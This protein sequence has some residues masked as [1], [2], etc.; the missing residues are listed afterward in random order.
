[1]KSITPRKRERLQT[2]LFNN[3]CYSI[4]VILHV[5]RM[6]RLTGKRKRME[7]RKEQAGRGKNSN[8]LR[9]KRDT[10]DRQRG[11]NDLR[12]YIHTRTER[13]RWQSPAPD[14]QLTFNDFSGYI[15][16][17]RASVSERL[18]TSTNGKHLVSFTV[19]LHVTTQLLS[20]YFSSLKV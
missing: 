2:G 12:I 11:F 17:D 15:T 20:L 6:N 9:L 4:G 18:R 7:E 1:M 14:C 5:I 8:W 3:Y 16:P 10:R 19:W 13:R